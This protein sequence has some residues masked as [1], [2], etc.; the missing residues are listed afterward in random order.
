MTSENTK[1]AGFILISLIVTFLFIEG[2]LRLGSWGFHYLQDEQNKKNISSNRKELVVLYLGEST[3]GWG[4]K[5]S[6]PSQLQ[7]IL[8]NTQHQVAFHIINKAI[9]ATDT[10]EIL[11]Q[12][13]SHIMK[14][15]PDI[16]LAMVGINDGYGQSYDIFYPPESLISSSSLRQSWFITLLSHSRVYGLFHWIADAIKHLTKQNNDVKTKIHLADELINEGESFDYGLRNPNTTHLLPRTILNLNTMVNLTTSKSIKFIFVQYALRKIDI[17]K[18]SIKGN[19]LYISNYEIF[20]DLQKK[21][22]YDELFIDNFANDFGHATTF[23]NR[24]IADNVAR[25]LKVFSGLQ[26]QTH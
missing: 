14:Y 10:N 7:R 1:R 24:I 16:V 9:P 15:K 6:W 5:N 11:K 21:Y 23:A 17:L 3:T 25:Q 19:A 12:L 2:L 4:G 22:D 26:N 8:N 18:N 20:H 13:P